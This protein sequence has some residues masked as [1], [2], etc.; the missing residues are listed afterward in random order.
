MDDGYVIHQSNA[1][2][3]VQCAHVARTTF[4]GRTHSFLACDRMPLVMLCAMRRRALYRMPFAMRRRHASAIHWRAPRTSAPL[5][6]ASWLL[7]LPFGVLLERPTGCSKRPGRSAP[8]KPAPLCGLLGFRGAHKNAT[9]GASCVIWISRIFA[10]FCARCDLRRR[11]SRERK[12][13]HCLLIVICF[14][15]AVDACL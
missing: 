2:C 4:R 12:P 14:V 5:S 10:F 6:L 15:R 13:G 3:V 7:V 1:A 11:Q 9:E 8:G